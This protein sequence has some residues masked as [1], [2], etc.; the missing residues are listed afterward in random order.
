MT[1][2][3]PDLPD[4]LDP[5]DRLDAPDRGGLPDRGDPAPIGRWYWPTRAASAPFRR[6]WFDVETVDADH[7]PATG[8]VILAPNHESF[9]DS[10]LLMYAL[11][12]KVVF[13]GKAEYLRSWK[14]RRLFPAAG[15]IP[16]DRSGRGLVTA[17]ERAATVLDGGGALGIFPEGTRS[18]DGLVHRGHNGVAHLALRTGAPIVPVG[19]TGTAEVQPPG[20][21]FPRRGGTIT[22]RFGAPVDLGP[23]IGRARSAGAR[24][25]ITEEVM[26]S[27]AT[28]CGK[29]YVDTHAPVP[30]AG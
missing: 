20:A 7:V 3:T 16:V 8:G 25:E 14:T 6:L 22:L 26:R 9:L 11:P 27:V 15:M 18:R 1:A 4:R 23:W 29:R 12:R 13:L 30:V 17:L 24:R 5:P 19:I 2:M 28:L 10:F 21:A